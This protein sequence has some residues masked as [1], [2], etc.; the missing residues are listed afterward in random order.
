MK[1]RFLILTICSWLS[2]AVS[3]RKPD[4]VEMLQSGNESGVCSSM[5]VQKD[6]KLVLQGGDEIDELVVYASPESAGQVVVDGGFAKIN[7]LVMKYTFVPGNWNFISFPGNFNIDEVSNLNELG[8]TYNATA[9]PYYI[10]EYS[11]KA[12]AEGK[13][14]WTVLGS[15]EV[16]RNKGYIMGVARTADNPNS[17]PVEVTFTFENTV[18]G[19]SSSAG[20]TMEVQLDFRSVEPGTTVP[21]YVRPD[22]V[23]GAPLKVMVQFQPTDLSYLPM[24]YAKEL[25]EARVTYNPPRTGI[26]LTLPDSSPAKVLI[27]GKHGNMVKA[28]RYKS[29]FVIDIS[30]LKSGEYE[31][32][33]EYGNARGYKEFT[34]D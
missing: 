10:R 9:K 22:G 14:A 25:E 20:G 15:P 11:T 30:D 7:R 33:V 17:E 2:V 26:R 21:V 6:E 3:A 5:V 27:F 16:M 13:S 28:V 1:I 8:Y 19:M 4:T 12:R 31:M 24:N 32:L 18:L 23:K 29:P 34:V